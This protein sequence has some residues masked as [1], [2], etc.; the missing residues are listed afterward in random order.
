MKEVWPIAVFVAS[1]HK[2]QRNNVKKAFVTCKK[3]REHL[4]KM[5]V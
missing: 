2:P 5:V 3:K 1:E 4:G